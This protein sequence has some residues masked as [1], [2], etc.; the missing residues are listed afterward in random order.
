MPTP[1]TIFTLHVI[2]II[3]ASL[4]PTFTSQSYTLN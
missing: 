4:N 1:L 3:K 2:S